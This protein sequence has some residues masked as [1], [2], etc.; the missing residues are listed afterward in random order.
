MVTGLIRGAGK[1]GAVLVVPSSNWEW[2]THNWFL[3][4]ASNQ[5]V[6]WQL[7]CAG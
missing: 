7:T 3:K 6:H 1:S 4:K 5:G 2:A